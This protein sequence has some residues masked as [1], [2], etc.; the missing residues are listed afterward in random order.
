LWRDEQ[1]AADELRAKHDYW[2]Q[3]LP[4]IAELI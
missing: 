1:S 4:D 2:R 3:W